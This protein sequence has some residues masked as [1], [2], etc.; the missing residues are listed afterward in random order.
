MP[1]V[2]MGLTGTTMERLLEFFFMVF[3]VET[4][5]VLKFNIH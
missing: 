3:L 4:I 2:S 5:K 1:G